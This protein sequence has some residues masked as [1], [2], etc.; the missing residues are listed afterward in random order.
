M[1][2][3]LDQNISFRVVKKITDR[4]P[5][6]SQVRLLGLE[7]YPDRKIWEYAKLYG[8]TVVTFDADFYD[9]AKLYGPPPKIIWLRTGNTTS[10]YIAQLLTIRA[11]VIHEF[12]ENPKYAQISCLE[13]D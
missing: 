10:N 6:A 4:F 13:M 1:K 8:Y 11:E 7:D 5:D 2:L 3:L 9:L 12:I